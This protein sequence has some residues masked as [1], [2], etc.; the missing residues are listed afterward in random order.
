VRRAS[1]PPLDDRGDAEV[2]VVGGG[3]TGLTTAWLLA[4][5]GRDVI[6]LERSRI[7]SGTSGAT[8]AHVT[9]VPDL[10]Y[11]R[12]I[13]NFG[14]KTGR[15]L[16]ARAGD[17]LALMTELIAA[18]SIRC[19]F[20]P[21][22]GYL[23]AEATTE[24]ADLEEEARA[25]RRLGRSCAFTRDVPLPWTVAGAVEFPGQAIFHPLRYLVGLAELT[26]RAGGAI[27]EHTSVTGY[28]VEGKGRVRIETLSATIRARHLILATHT[29][30]GFSLVQTEVAPYRSYVVSR[31]SEKAFPE[32]L[33]WDTA[34]PYHYLRRVEI[35][36][37]AL[38][39]VGGADHKSAHEQDPAARFAEL[40][41]YC[42]PR[43]GAGS[44]ARC[45]SA[46][47]YE[48]A[49]GLPYIGPIVGSDSV[50]IA[51][52]FSGTGLVF[53]TMA[54][55]EL[56]AIL[57]G[58]K[59]REYPFDAK[60]LRLAAAPRLASENADVAACW[61]GDRFAAGDR[62]SFAD[63][64][65]GEGAIVR[66]G[67]KRRAVFHAD[68]GTLHV[69]SP[70]CP[71]M[72]CHVRWNGVERSWDCPCHG[73]RFAAT[74]EVIEGPALRGLERDMSSAKARAEARKAGATDTRRGRHDARDEPAAPASGDEI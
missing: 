54:A 56:A 60:R 35:D 69:F 44:T 19:D 40:E 5:E 55:L 28:E 22:S 32:G 42:V 58:D 2:V 43:L 65:P 51:T 34:D 7:G 11:R 71:H 8:S 52:G 49:D 15:L 9:D 63:V 45:W 57:R 41:A 66:S 23:F 30:I 39:L 37:E 25:A 36:D 38:V 67:G 61:V 50:C 1:Y 4:R 70:V 59:R 53:G 74:G 29:P 46:Q 48:P 16:V 24:R 33:F 13:K 18:E 62:R 64:S 17:A 27:H 31:E 12:L 20:A 10:R 6:L 73:A 72:G 47:F 14:E 3:I 21:V 68:D 26:K